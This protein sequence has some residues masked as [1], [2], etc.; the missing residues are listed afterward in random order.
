MTGAPTVIHGNDGSTAAGFYPR[1]LIDPSS[2]TAYM[3]SA[4]I[5]KARHRRAVGEQPQRDRPGRA[6]ANAR[7]SAKSEVRRLR[8]AKAGRL[9]C[10]DAE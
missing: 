6:V 1:I 7:V 10:F 9:V 2:G 3:S 8:P 5:L 4:I